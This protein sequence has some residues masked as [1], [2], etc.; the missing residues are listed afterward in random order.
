MADDHEVV[1]RGI[2]AA[3]ER[4]PSLE[5]CGVASNGQE[6]IERVLEIKPDVII[7]DLSMPVLSGF[8]ATLKIRQ[9]A[10]S[11]K[12]VVFSVH[13]SAEVEQ[14]AYLLGADA[15]VRKNS[16]LQDLLSTVNSVLKGPAGPPSGGSERSSA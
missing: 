16:P 4:Q 1:R 12:I 15:Y 2:R 14:V 11:T 9:Q 3:L 5:V 10:P 7:M 6:A 13:E 8:Q